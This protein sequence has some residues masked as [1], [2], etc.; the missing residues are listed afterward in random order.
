MAGEGMTVA[1]GQTWRRM[2]ATARVM[3]VVEGYVVYRFKGAMPGLMHWK[4]FERE[5]VRV[6]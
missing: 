3:V 2:G 5:F 1:K 4:A 6:E